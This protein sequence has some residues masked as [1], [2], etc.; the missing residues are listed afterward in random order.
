MSSPSHADKGQSIG[1]KIMTYVGS[2]LLAQLIVICVVFLY[3]MYATLV[4]GTMQNIGANVMRVAAEIEARNLEAVTVA[5]TMAEAQENGLFGKR[6]ESAAYARQVL[7]DS[8]QF[9]GAYFGYEPNADQADAEYKKTAG[10]DAEG[11]DA[12]GRFLPYWF[13]DKT[14]PRKLLL[15]P[16]IDMSTSLYYHGVKEKLLS[17]APQKYLITEPYVYEGKMI[18]EQTYPIVVDGAFKGIAGVDRSLTAIS[19]FLRERKP[20]GSSEFILVSRLGRIIVN[21]LDDSLETKELGNTR[22]SQMF[23]TVFQSDADDK[24]VKV[25]RDPSDEQRYFF[26]GATIGTGEWRVLMR[27]AQTEVLAPVLHTL[28][29]AGGIVVLGVLATVA[30]LVSLARSVARPIRAAANAAERVAEGDL[31]AVVDV[32]ADGEI[33]QLLDSLRTMTANLNSLARE[34]QRSG[35]QVTSSSTQIAASARQIEATVS[36]QAASTNEVLAT[37]TE[38]TG[39]SK[40]LVQVIGEVTGAVMGT[41]EMA[42]VGRSDLAHMETAM[43]RLG[44]STLSISSRLSVINDKTTNVNSVVATISKVADQTNLLSLNAAI[45][46]E[47]AGEFGRG[48]AVVAREIRRLADQT[49]VATMDIDRMVKEMQSAVDAGV[50]EMDK[51]AKEVSDIVAEVN[52]ISAQQE[53]II[54]KVQDITPAFAE[55]GTGVRSQAEAAEQIREAMVRLSEGAGQTAESV[56]EFKRTATQLNEAA[57]GLQEAMAGFKVGSNDDRGADISSRR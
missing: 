5:K 25:L 43:H 41:A 17:G 26:G 54:Q 49:A 32:D 4:D 3:G 10:A 6:P 12:A 42:G 39:V 33:G 29:W 23:E 36:G 56:S 50:M 27:V 7:Q 28:A 37:T 8:P 46:A 20:Y 22:Y 2:V 48:F 21:T 45:E 51:F 52:R 11:L 44:E 34:V 35:I 55:A 13:R 1:R 38:I 47:K 15:H 57:S 9:T 31:T 14:D 24:R 19:T 16:L 53:C 18:V 30:V 40:S